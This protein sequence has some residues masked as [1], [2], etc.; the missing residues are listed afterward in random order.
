M[1]PLVSHLHP[2]VHAVPGRRR[3]LSHTLSKNSSFVLPRLRH[4]STGYEEGRD[5]ASSRRG[6]V[7]YF[8]CGFG[9]RHLTGF[10]SLPS[11]RLETQK[12][13]RTVSNPWSQEPVIL[14][15]RYPNGFDGLSAGTGAPFLFRPQDLVFSSSVASEKHYQVGFLSQMFA[16]VGLSR[17]QCTPLWLPE[18]NLRCLQ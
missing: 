12:K 5:P 6:F 1:L 14:P 13:L 17:P 7:A 15:S 18:R 3:N 2:P 9:W 10:L 11:C 8:V 16:D 4:H